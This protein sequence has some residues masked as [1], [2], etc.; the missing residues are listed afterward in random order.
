MDKTQAGWH[1]MMADC[2]RVGRED[3]FIQAKG[4]PPQ[5][6]MRQGAAASASKAATRSAERASEHA[7]TRTG[8][9]TDAG[10]ALRA[11]GKPGSKEEM[12]AAH[13]AAAGAHNFAAS[14]HGIAAEMHERAAKAG[15][16]GS[17]AKA[18]HHWSESDYHAGEANKHAEQA[19]SGEWDEGKHPRDENGKFA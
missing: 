11:T 10:H 7:E 3:A 2:A 4:V 12:K 15:V 13:M 1:Q 6:P 18:E 14:K 5:Y 8:A 17:A 9:L 16:Q 19:T